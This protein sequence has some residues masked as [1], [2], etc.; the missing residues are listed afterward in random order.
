MTT[1]TINNNETFSIDIAVRES[2]KY[3]Q[4]VYMRVDMNYHTEGFRGTHEVFMTTE[5]MRQLGYFLV[6]EAKMIEAEQ[7]SRSFLKDQ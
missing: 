7:K 2:D 3:T 5:E 1:H 6:N 4:S